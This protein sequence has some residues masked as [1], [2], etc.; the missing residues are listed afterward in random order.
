MR[1]P[2][3]G[4]IA[5]ATLFE[6]VSA[7]RAEAARPEAALFSALE[8]LMR[9]PFVRRRSDARQRFRLVVS[10]SISSTVWMI[11]AFDE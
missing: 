10:C 7:S 2:K 11:L 1:L 4:V 5:F 6:M 3:P 8:M 9:G